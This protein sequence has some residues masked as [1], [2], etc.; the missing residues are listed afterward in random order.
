MC[1]SVSAG[2][3]TLLF[4]DRFSGIGQLSVGQKRH[5]GRLEIQAGS[6]GGNATPEARGTEEALSPGSGRQLNLCRLSRHPS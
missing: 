2:L 3:V 6:S 5:A 1:V 4:I